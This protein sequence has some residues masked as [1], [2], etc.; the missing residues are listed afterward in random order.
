[1][2][3]QEAKKFVREMKELS[4]EQTAIEVRKGNKFWCNKNSCFVHSGV[5]L[6]R[7]T[8]RKEGCVRCA[9]GRMVRKTLEQKAKRRPGIEL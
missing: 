7:Q 1:M 3:T 6:S 8:K 4:L 9:Q 5:C 2:D